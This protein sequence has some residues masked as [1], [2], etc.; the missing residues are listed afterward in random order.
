MI[1]SDTRTPCTGIGRIPILLA[2]VAP[3]PA[4]RGWKALVFRGFQ[5][6]TPV[7]E[8]DA[9]VET[10]SSLFTKN[11]GNCP[12]GRFFKISICYVAFPPRQRRGYPNEHAN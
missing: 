8:L 6:P 4:E 3:A 2:S 12:D 9:A 11:C 7:T 1:D 10:T 5:E